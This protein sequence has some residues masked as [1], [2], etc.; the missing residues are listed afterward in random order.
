MI[1]FC[2]KCV[3]RNLITWS[4]VRFFLIW[5]RTTAKSNWEQ[6]NREKKVLLSVLCLTM[7]HRPISS[8][9]IQS[10]VQILSSL[11]QF[12][13]LIANEKKKEKY[14]IAVHMSTV[15]LVV[16]SNSRAH[17]QE[18]YWFKQK[19][20]EKRRE[21]KREGINKKRNEKSTRTHTCRSG[22]TYRSF[23]RTI[24]YR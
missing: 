18:D 23:T 9:L 8:H 16:R 1:S 2:N 12:R 24:F 17:R 15:S 3:E 10:I 21:K 20:K 11:Q 7:E 13:Y 19:G 6:K 22:S 4:T 5:R 14:T